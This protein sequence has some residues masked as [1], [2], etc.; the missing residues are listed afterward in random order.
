MTSPKIIRERQEETIKRIRQHRLTSAAYSILQQ[1]YSR[2]QFSVKEVKVEEDYSRITAFRTR[3]DTGKNEVYHIYSSPAWLEDPEYVELKNRIGTDVSDT[4]GDS[5]Q[6]KA[7]MIAD[8][9]GMVK[10]EKLL[11]SLPI[12]MLLVFSRDNSSVKVKADDVAMEHFFAA[13]PVQDEIRF[14]DNFPHPYSTQLDPLIKFAFVSLNY[15]RVGKASLST[16]LY[17]STAE[18]YTY[19]VGE[20]RETI[21]N[22]LSELV[23]DMDK[24]GVITARSNEIYFPKN[25]QRLQ[26]TFIRKYWDYV[27]KLGKRTLFDFESPF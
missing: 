23:Q 21:R 4:I 2:L 5:D 7:V 9:K 15:A 27:E 19:S 13:K 24:A 8:E 16:V 12:E 18:A 25:S 22:D 3:S 26:K 10:P 11:E 17:E 6:A 20:E 1:N 14:I